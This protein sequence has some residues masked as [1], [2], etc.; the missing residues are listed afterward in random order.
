M[1]IVTTNYASCFKQEYKTNAHTFTPCGT[2]NERFDLIKRQVPNGLKIKTIY[3][4]K[5]CTS[6]RLCSRCN[7]LESQEKHRLAI[8]ISDNKQ[9]C[10]TS[11]NYSTIIIIILFNSKYNILGYT[12]FEM[13]IYRRRFSRYVSNR[14]M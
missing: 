6:S 10:R 13:R 8:D 3:S 2:S 9:V 14:A 4:C 1:L 11:S 12:T 5:L 7:S